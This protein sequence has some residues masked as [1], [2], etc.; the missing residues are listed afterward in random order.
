M[1]AAQL[2][3][4]TM[5]TESSRA[6]NIK[7]LCLQSVKAIKDRS[8]SQ[9]HTTD[10]Q[11]L[12]TQEGL[13]IGLGGSDVAEQLAELATSPSMHS[14]REL[15]RFGVSNMTGK[16]TRAV[17]A[18]LNVAVQG[19]REGWLKEEVVSRGLTRGGHNNAARNEEVGDSIRSA[20]SSIRT[21]E[22]LHVEETGTSEWRASLQPEVIKQVYGLSDNGRQIKSSLRA[23]G[24]SLTWV[25]K[26]IHGRQ[27]T[28]D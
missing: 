20:L 7:D 26:Y 3:S 4:H 9:S 10:T 27:G 23:A 28:L 18:V 1:S 2:F 16:D 22:G 21:L 5:S 8:E 13:C 17:D 6:V 11:I 14:F 25:S 12:L 15:L 24:I 19:E